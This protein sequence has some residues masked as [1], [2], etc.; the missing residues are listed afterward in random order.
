MPE[1]DGPNNE[2]KK[3]KKWKLAANAQYQDAMKIV[4]NLATASL[5]L[6][7]VLI[8]DFLPKGAV[9]GAHL[10]KWASWSWGSFLCRSSYSCCSS[11]R[12]PST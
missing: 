6:P 1:N 7:I 2:T 3:D 10:N 11:M 9:I 12:Q 4:V 5:V 8:K